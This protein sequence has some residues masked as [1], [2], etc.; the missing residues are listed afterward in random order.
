[1]KNIFASVLFSLSV[2]SANAAL[3]SMAG[4]NYVDMGLAN[5]LDLLPSLS[6]RAGQVLTIN[7]EGTGLEWAPVQGKVAIAYINGTP[8]AASGFTISTTFTTLRKDMRSGIVSLN[9]VVGRSAAQSLAV[10]ASTHI[11]TL[12]AD[13]RP[14]GV[15]QIWVPVAGYSGVREPNTL[16][17]SLGSD[18]S[19]HVFNYGSA[20]YTIPASSQFGVN[21][22]FRAALP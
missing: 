10:G 18:G 19:I 15:P 21:F 16:S 14:V 12:P 11:A 9:L 13:F 20:A 2:F 6:G 1:M 17:A 5:K 3:F 7:A 22:V 8:V 4:K